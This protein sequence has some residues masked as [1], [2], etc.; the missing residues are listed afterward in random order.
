MTGKD[1][2]MLSLTTD[3][4]P[5]ELR[6][7]LVQRALTALQEMG[8][9]VTDIPQRGR[10]V[11]W[12]IRKNGTEQLAAL[13]TTRDR[14]IAFT[15]VGDSWKTLDDVDRVIV[16]AVDDPEN[17]KNAVIYDF[18]ASE[19]QQRFDA[20]Y[21]ARVDAGHKVTNN[22][23]MWVGLDGGN[24]EDPGGVGCGLADEFGVLATMPLMD[25]PWANWSVSVD[26]DPGAGGKDVETV[27]DVLSWAQQRIADISG[28]PQAS[29]RLDL[30]ISMGP[31][32]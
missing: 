9:E 27:S 22:F 15:R 20:A 1:K 19:V 11:M 30:H 6:R 12:K 25:G 28:V 4:K 16:S 18:P 10:S 31:K 2:K 29:V 26:T 23:G 14:C 21:R 7:K 8:Y 17:P 3:L 13:R 24:D 32:E 5:A